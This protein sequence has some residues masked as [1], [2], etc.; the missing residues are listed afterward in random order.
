MPLS[1]SDLRFDLRISLLML[2]LLLSRFNPEKAIKEIRSDSVT[3]NYKEAF[4]DRTNTE[5]IFKY[6][7][8][9]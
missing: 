1:R 2:I 4:K 5:F 8:L 6:I 7:H 9:K 3:L